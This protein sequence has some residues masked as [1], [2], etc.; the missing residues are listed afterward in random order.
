M[1][2]RSSNAR[3]NLGENDLGKAIVTIT[4]MSSELQKASAD[5]KN[6]RLMRDI[7]TQIMLE[8][9]V[10]REITSEPLARVKPGFLSRWLGIK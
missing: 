10:V 6:R 5:G 2:F 9:E 7:A 4:R 3:L 1:I 8:C